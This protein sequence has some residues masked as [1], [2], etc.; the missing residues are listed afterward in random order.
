MRVAYAHGIELCQPLIQQRPDVAA[1]VISLAMFYRDLSRTAKLPGELPQAVQWDERAV[2][3]LQAFTRQHPDN[4]HAAR[5]L[6]EV[7][8]QYAGHLDA[9]ERRDEA[10]QRWSEAIELYPRAERSPTDGDA[11]VDLLFLARLGLADILRQ[12]GDYQRVLTQA[13]KMAAENTDRN[14]SFTAARL[15]A[16]V[17]SAVGQD[18][19]RA[20]A[21]RNLLAA[22]FL[23]AAINCLT[24]A[25][26]AG[27]FQSR[28]HRQQL[29]EDPV[30]RILEDEERF[31]SLLP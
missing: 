7:L 5:L 30:F 10:I 23:D 11:T 2:E 22:R 1:F 15:F 14:S 9:A 8:I 4:R 28:A 6:L 17:A 29:R 20:E 26:D 13:E 18:L 19:S 3:A 25:A 16:Y 21:D 27:Y 31:R 12:A 24:R